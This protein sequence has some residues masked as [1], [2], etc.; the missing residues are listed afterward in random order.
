MY[1]P[2]VYIKD[3]FFLPPLSEIRRWS[4]VKHRNCS[5]QVYAK[6][7]LAL[8]PPSPQRLSKE[9][10]WKQDL[11]SCSVTILL[12]LSVLPPIYLHS[13]PHVKFVCV[14]VS[15]VTSHWPSGELLILLRLPGNKQLL[16]HMCK[17]SVFNIVWMNL[18]LEFM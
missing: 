15:R 10:K 11:P 7:S 6:D 2:E 5:P 12:C 16:Q 18:A 3:F 17:R 8:P 4:E 1:S 13:F 14:T 9:M